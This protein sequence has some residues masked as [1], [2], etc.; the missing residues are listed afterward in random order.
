M[1]RSFLILLLFAG[2]PQ[3][4]VFKKEMGPLQTVVETT[5][6]STGARVFSQPKATYLDGYGI[7]V[8]V[9]AMLEQPPNIFSTPKSPE[10]VKATVNQRRKDVREK[11]TELMKQQIAKSTSIGETE[12]LAVIVHL[13]P[14]TRA[15]AGDQPTQMVLSVKKGAPTQVNV[16]EF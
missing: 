3:V 4:D 1:L 11:L 16:R 5:I 13:L 7:V 14:T 2:S 10:H 9:E 6:S 8:S 12:S 15:D